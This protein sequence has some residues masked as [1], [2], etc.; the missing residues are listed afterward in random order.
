M[1]TSKETVVAESLESLQ[2]LL[3]EAFGD[4]LVSILHYGASVDQDLSSVA[5]ADAEI[6][7][8]IVVE[9]LANTDWGKISRAF[10]RL[11]GRA[12]VIPV[13]L[14]ENSLKSSTDVFPI[15]IRELKS[16][17]QLVYGKDVVA[18]LDYQ[19][20]H[21]RLRCEQELRALQLRMQGIC[22]MHFASPHRLRS[23]LV[24]DYKTFE[25]LLQIAMSLS[26]TETLSG[27][28]TLSGRQLLEAAAAKLEIEAEPLVEALE[29]ADGNGEFDEESF[30]YHYID[31]MTSVRMTADLVDQLTIA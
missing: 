13:L 8:L 14:T 15:L 17:S 25:P 26:G 31:L 29:F 7:V 30:G 18:D 27:A 6:K 2:G 24:R 1:A 20:A 12:S 23:A 10:D 3:Q 5:S 9:V 21:L 22:L 11:R 16:G 19:P 28:E 4:N